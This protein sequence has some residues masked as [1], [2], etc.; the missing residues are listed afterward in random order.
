MNSCSSIAN[1][2]RYADANKSAAGYEY[3]K[4]E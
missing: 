1:N 2:A 4:L 3:E